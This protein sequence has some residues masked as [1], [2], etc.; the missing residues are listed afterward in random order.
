[1]FSRGWSSGRWSARTA[2]KDGRYSANRFRCDLAHH[3]CPTRYRSRALMR[4]AMGGRASAHV[5]AYGVAY[6]SVHGE[7]PRRA[8][9]NDPAA[10]DLS[11]ALAAMESRGPSHSSPV[12]RW[13]EANY[14]ALAVAFRRKPPSWTKLASYL[15]EHG[16]TGAEDKRPTPASVRS[17]WRRL[18]AAKVRQRGPSASR[19][20]ETPGPDPQSPDRRGSDDVYDFAKTPFVR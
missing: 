12:H 14:D 6:V 5:V 18:D 8:M 10:P 7:R 19:H 1:M 3:G 17:A 13:L 11:E 20:A 2:T 15:S 16:V 9:V 4:P